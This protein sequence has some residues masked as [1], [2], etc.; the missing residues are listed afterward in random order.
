MEVIKLSKCNSELL[1]NVDKDI[2]DG[3]IS[4]SRL[5]EFVNTENH[6]ALVAVH[7]ELVVGQVIAY[8][9][10]HIDSPTEL[11]ID[12]LGV[13]LDFRRKGVATKLI[14]ALC[15]IGKSY[16]CEDVW[17]AAEVDNEAALSFYRAVKLEMVPAVVFDGKLR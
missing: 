10:R 6:I 12:N 15:V 7:K 5:A 13:S 14:E 17:V 2:F 11:Y 8:V 3:D 16:G 1:E 4:S 9:H